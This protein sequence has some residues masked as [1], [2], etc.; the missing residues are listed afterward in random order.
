[1]EH[2]NSTVITSPGRFGPASGDLLSTPSRTSFF[3]A[4]M[5]SASVRDRSSRSISNA[6]TCLA[7]CGWPKASPQYYGP[8]VLSRAGLEDLGS[9][10]RRFGDLIETVTMNPGREVR[11]AEEMS[12]MAPFTDGG[13]TIDRT[14]WSNTY[15]SYYPFGGAIALALDLSLRGGRRP[16]HARRFHARDVARA[17][18][19]GGARR[20]RRSSLHARRCRARLAEV[21]GDA[22]FAR[23]FFARYI[24]G[25]EVPDY[26]KLL[27][28]RRFRD[29]AG[30]SRSGVVGRLRLD[31]GTAS[32]LVGAAREHAGLQSRPRRR[33]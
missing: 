30:E 27:Q 14:N 9:T 21:S 12:R 17:R 31:G 15:I 7:S 19:T 18:Q 32:S 1:M 23:E 25:R 4:G 2:R 33:R 29:P 3:T 11:S 8:L 13:Q 20:L 16:R 10:R 6:P 5:S 22:A 28:A 26:A 24:H